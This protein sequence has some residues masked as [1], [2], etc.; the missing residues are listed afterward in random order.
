MFRSRKS[1][2]AVLLIILL[3]LFVWYGSA[4]PEPEKGYYP[5]SEHVVQDREAYVGEKVDI[6]GR[7][8]ETDPLTI[9][10]EYGDD[11][12]LLEIVNTSKD[13]DVGDRVSVFGTLNENHTI[14]AETMIV[15]PLT[16]WYYMYGV[17]GAAAIWLLVRLISHWKYTPTGFKPREEPLKLFR[18]DEDG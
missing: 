7:V 1:M 5:G 14:T 16:N 6:G 4:S 8:V 9:E 12:I 10:V 11:S 18:R 17:S 3:I 15:R 13:A 2:I